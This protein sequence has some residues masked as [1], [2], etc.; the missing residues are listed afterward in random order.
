MQIMATLPQSPAECMAIVL[1]LHL[2]KTFIY[3]RRAIKNK[4]SISFIQLLILLK[5]YLNTK[6]LLQLTF[7]IYSLFFIKNKIYF[8]SSSTFLLTKMRKFTLNFVDA[9]T[10]ICRRPMA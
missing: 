3:I 5:N 8:I 6:I 10:M 2:C 1:N 4:F 7:F 9:S